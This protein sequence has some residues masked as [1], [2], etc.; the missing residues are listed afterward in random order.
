M[1]KD[2][3]D[4]FGRKVNYR[5][6]CQEYYGYTDEEMSGMDVHHIDGNRQNNDPTNL[7]LLTPEEHAKIHKDEFVLWARKGSKLGNAAFKKRMKEKGP[8]A[9][10]LV[11]YNRR[12]KMFKTNPIHTKAVVGDGV[13][14]K[15]HKEAAEATGLTR[16]TIR[17][18]IKNPRYDWHYA[19]N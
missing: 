15:T 8:T 11:E 16:Q 13:F 18:R 17:N 19:D 5:K 12:R 14:Y 9:K 7:Q 3:Y 10:E 2:I 1:S 4:E 6:I